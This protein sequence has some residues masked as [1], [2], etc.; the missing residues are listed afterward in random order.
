MEHMEP[1]RVSKALALLRRRPSWAILLAA[2]TLLTISTWPQTSPARPD[3]VPVATPV[4]NTGCLAFYRPA[5]PRTVVASIRDFG[6]VGDGRTLN[7]L[8]F[9]R[10]VELLKEFGEQGGSQLTLV[11]VVIVV[12]AFLK[13]RVYEI[14]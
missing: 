1:W 5:T 2:M 10:A 3:A 13:F 12:V 4:A 7:T 14:R 11:V 9:R 6:G 8:A